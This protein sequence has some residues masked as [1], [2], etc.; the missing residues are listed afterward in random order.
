VELVVKFF[1]KCNGS[2]DRFAAIMTLW[3]APFLV[4]PDYPLSKLDLATTC[5]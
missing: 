3:L 5:R 2:S 1:E 4:V